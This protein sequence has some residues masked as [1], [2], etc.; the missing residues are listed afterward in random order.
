MNNKFIIIDWINKNTK[1]NLLIS[2]FNEK[3]D[4]KL[5]E[6]EILELFKYYFMGFSEEE[7]QEESMDSL[8]LMI[9]FKD[10]KS[11]EILNI[12]LVD[13][14]FN[15]ED[16]YDKTDEIIN[17]NVKDLLKKKVF[18]K[19]KKPSIIVKKD[20]KYRVIKK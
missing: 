11:K 8:R 15:L 6:N 10:N 16:V 20:K 13:K 2:S 1:L 19:R 4:L 9:T 5:K 7:E 14:N 18:Y 17:I 3:F 12:S